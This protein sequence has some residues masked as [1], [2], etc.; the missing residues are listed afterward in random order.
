MFTVD[1]D[2]NFFLGSESAA[3]FCGEQIL[4]QILYEPKIAIPTNLGSTT[5]QITMF[6]Y[7]LWS[8]LLLTKT[9]NLLKF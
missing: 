2:S 7:S 6:F 9:F 1:P 5:L 3:E 4:T 8:D